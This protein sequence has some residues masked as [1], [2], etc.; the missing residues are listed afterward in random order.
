MFPVIHFEKLS[1]LLGEFEGVYPTPNQTIRVSIQQRTETHNNSMGGQKII[2]LQC[3]V[4]SLHNGT[5]LS[6]MPYE[7]IIKIDAFTDKDKA[8]QQ[9]EDAL[10]QL[11]L[12]KEQ[13]TEIII[14]EGHTPRP[15]VLDLGGVQP[16][17]GQRWQIITE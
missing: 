2:T 1:D 12:T 11:H 9:Y 14:D 13:I 15:G 7:E 5:I 8:H 10:E 16:V 4:R 6:Y 17:A 3:F